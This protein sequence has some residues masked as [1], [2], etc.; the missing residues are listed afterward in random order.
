ML[1]TMG[2]E[3]QL[4]D[5]A[6]AEMKRLESV[7]EIAQELSD[8]RGHFNTLPLINQ[9][10]SAVERLTETIRALPMGEEL[11]GPELER[12]KANPHQV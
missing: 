1:L 6:V 10:A 3:S 4:R 12:W 8:A 2:E 11:V 9:T 5:L 7:R